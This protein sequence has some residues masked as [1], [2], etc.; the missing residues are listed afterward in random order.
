[1]KKTIFTAILV[2]LLAAFSFSAC[3]LIPGGSAKEETTEKEEKT[4]KKT[5]KNSGTKKKNSLKDKAKEKK[6]E[7]EEQP[8]EEP[9]ETV[10]DKPSEQADV[11]GNGGFFIRVGDSVYFHRTEGDYYGETL[12]GRD[13]LYDVGVEEDVATLCRYD[14]RTGETEELCTD[15]CTGRM[16]LCGDKIFYSRD[17]GADGYEVWFVTLDGSEHSKWCPGEVAGVS[18]EGDRLA[19]DGYYDGSRFLMAYD[20]NMDHVCS[21][22]RFSDPI[23]FCGFSHK[24]MF[25]LEQEDGKV[26]CYSARNDE[27]EH[28]CYGELS[29]N[30]GFGGPYCDRFLSDGDM[31]YMLCA[32]YGGPVNT[33]EDYLIVGMEMGNAGSLSELQHGYDAKRMP[34]VESY[35]EPY[36]FVKDG[37]LT[38]QPHDQN[39]A[40]LSEGKYG[41]LMM[42]KDGEG[43]LITDD[44]I[45]EEECDNLL[46]Q[47]GLVM[48]DAA[49]LMIAA[50]ERVP[51]E[52]YKIFQAFRLSQIYPMRLDFS[53]R[54]NF[55]QL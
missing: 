2:L 48:G 45:R 24:E 28:V 53:D 35:E 25:Y 19:I 4:E 21:V 7:P 32:W 9:E 33:V 1:M 39:E 18:P 20:E 38:Y 31:V 41:D 34:G 14:I 22:P 36:L 6:A 55:V 30:G 37:E 5:K 54:D 16:Y 50:A 42:W 46:L 52:D 44:A 10:P 43:S 11:E 47:K 40:Y 29:L 27:A 49:Y 17:M 23:E 26:S 13:L 8:E 15:G 3:S 51:E 12:L